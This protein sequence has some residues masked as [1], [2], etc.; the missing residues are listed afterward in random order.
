M[1]VKDWHA[2][3]NELDVNEPIENSVSVER[4]MLSQITKS[5]DHRG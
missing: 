5:I 4:V 3:A 2:G 1:R